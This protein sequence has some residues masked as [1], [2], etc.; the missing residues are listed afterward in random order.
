MIEDK[1]IFERSTIK[2]LADAIRLKRGITNELLGSQFEAEVLS[3]PTAENLDIEL[4]EHEN[5]IAELEEEIEN[6]GD[7]E[8]S[9]LELVIGLQ[10]VNNPYTITQAD[11][12]EITEIP[13][14]FFYQKLGLTKV[15][16]ESVTKLSQYAF[17]GCNNL[18]EIDLPNVEDIGIYCFQYCN[19]MKRFDFPKAKTIGQRAFANSTG[20]EYI[21]ISNAETIGTYACN[22]CTYLTGVKMEKVDTIDSYAFQSCYRLGYIEIPATCTKIAN[23]VFSNV[24]RAT[25][26]EKAIYRFLGDT[27]PSIYAN[28][29]NKDYIDK[30]IVN[31]GCGEVYKTA[32]NWANFADYIVE[33]EE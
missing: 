24:G 12:G 14:Y 32:T 8:V 2:G 26:N 1:V 4:T 7:K 33:V 16:I 20:V 29:F 30:I 31:K 15:A 6:L 17:N 23:N 10:D 19:G 28:T 9:K 5:S 3:I 13:Q 25:D 21:D 18:V 11:V 22:S 27:P